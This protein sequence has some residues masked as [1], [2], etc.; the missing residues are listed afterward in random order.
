MVWLHIIYLSRLQ[1]IR[2][3]HSNTQNSVNIWGQCFMFVLFNH[4]TACWSEVCTG[5]IFIYLMSS[6][7]S[8][9]CPHLCYD[10]FSTLL[11]LCRALQIAYVWDCALGQPAFCS[12][13]KQANHDVLLA[14]LTFPFFI[15]RN[16]LADW[17]LLWKCALFF[18]AAEGERQTTWCLS[19]NANLWSLC[20]APVTDH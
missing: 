17:P 20:C 10:L 1:F 19:E 18:I 13:A 7:L 3:I 12:K 15:C 4:G 16:E 9:V 6:V 8:C 2:Q 14:H 11:S 5:I